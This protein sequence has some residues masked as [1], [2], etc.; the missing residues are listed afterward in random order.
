MRATV[1]PAEG[2]IVPQEDGRDWPSVDGRP[3]ALDVEATM[4]IR[5]R[6]ADGDLVRSPVDSLAPADMPAETPADGSIDLPADPPRE[7]PAAGTRRRA[8]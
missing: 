7:T 8:I 6:L 5:R 2:R 3:V 1:I 4:Y